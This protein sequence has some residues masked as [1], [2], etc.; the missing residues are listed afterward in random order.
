MLFECTTWFD[1]DIVLVTN[2]LPLVGYV[3]NNCGGRANETCTGSKIWT[4]D[5]RAKHHSLLVNR[6]SVGRQVRL[7]PRRPLRIRSYC[8][9]VGNNVPSV[10][11]R[12]T[13]AISKISWESWRL[14]IRQLIAYLTLSCNHITIFS[15]K[16]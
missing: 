12:C 14:L 4:D 1:I 15:G 11:M 10:Y 7:L 16:L 2:I 6:V 8:C 3:T 5:D 13:S 9:H